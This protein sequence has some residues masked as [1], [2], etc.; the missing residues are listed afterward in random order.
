MTDFFASL[1]EWFGL[2]PFYSQDFGDHLRGWDITCT[3][4]MGTPWYNYIGVIMIG[5]TIFGFALQY[6][7]IDSTRFNRARSWWVFTGATVFMNFLIAFTITY[8]DI[9]AENYCN[10]LHI[11]IGDCAGFALSN[12]LWSFIILTTISSIPIVRKMSTNCR[13]TTFW[14]P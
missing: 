4:Y 8:N 3:D 5:V 1:Y 9:Q 2:V 10:Q 11:G 13:H 14:K 6:Y 7:I 12:L